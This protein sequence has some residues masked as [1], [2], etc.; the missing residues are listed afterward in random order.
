MLGCVRV[1]YV[2]VWYDVLWYILYG[3]FS[4]T[5]D[6]PGSSGRNARMALATVVVVAD[7]PASSNS[8]T[9]LSSF[10]HIAAYFDMGDKLWSEPLSLC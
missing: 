4:M 10:T 3:V 1:C 8:S 7:T 6:A 5:M 9:R 2:M